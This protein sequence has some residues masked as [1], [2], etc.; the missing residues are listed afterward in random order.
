MITL[1]ESLAPDA[2]IRE[3]SAW[4]STRGDPSLAMLHSGQERQPAQTDSVKLPLRD[5]VAA[6]GVMRETLSQWLPSFEQSGYFTAAKPGPAA[7]R[8]VN[9]AECAGLLLSAI[10]YELPDEPV[11]RWS[12]RFVGDWVAAIVYPHWRRSRDMLAAQHGLHTSEGLGFTDFVGDYLRVLSSIPRY[13]LHSGRELSWTSRYE[14]DAEQARLIWPRIQAWN[15]GG[16]SLDWSKEGRLGFSGSLQAYVRLLEQAS[17]QLVAALRRAS[18]G[19]GLPKAA[20]NEAVDVAAYGIFVPQGAGAADQALLAWAVRS[21]LP[22]QLVLSGTPRVLLRADGDAEASV[23]PV[24]RLLQQCTL[25]HEHFHAIVETGLD[26]GFAQARAPY[27]DASAWQ[28]AAALN[29]AL[30]VWMEIE[31]LRRHAAALGSPQDVAAA[32]DAVWAYVRAGDYPAWPY[33]GAE[34]I[35][36]RHAAQG[37]D[38]IRALLLRLR[39]DPGGALREFES[40]TGR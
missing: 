33:R 25:V 38:G 7:L 10:Y 12:D 35:E 15:I 22:A 30:A 36:T 9:L 5:V 37:I 3:R 13:W 40:G 32:L 11:R 29:E 26:R 1:W 18:G 8:C 34:A 31:F 21:G 17:G 27:T 24:R 2:N 20:A 28:R 14:T 4:D 6:L 39:R 16:L 19:C 23:P